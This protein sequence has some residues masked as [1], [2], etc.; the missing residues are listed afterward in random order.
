MRLHVPVPNFA[1]VVPPPPRPP[2]RLRRLRARL[3]LASCRRKSRGTRGISLTM[4]DRVRWTEYG[5][6]A[7]PLAR[8]SELRFATTETE[9]HG[10]H[11]QSVVDE[12]RKYFA[13]NQQALAAV[14][15]R[16][17]VGTIHRSKQ[18]A[19]REVRRTPSGPY[20]VLYDKS[21]TASSFHLAPPRG[22]PPRLPERVEVV[23]R[24]P[25][26]NRRLNSERSVFV[27]NEVGASVK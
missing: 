21:I 9:T 23:P 5:S 22:I 11:S 1:H 19:P 14:L 13:L 17:D 2:P 18:V 20:N 27:V 24:S 26:H 25:S 7:H 4:A 15:A 8:E 3:T 12:F 16:Q 6:P 10:V